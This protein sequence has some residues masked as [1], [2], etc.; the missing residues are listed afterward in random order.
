MA[1]KFDQAPSFQLNSAPGLRGRG[2]LL[3]GVPGRGQRRLPPPRVPRQRDAGRV[4]LQPGG[5]ARPQDG[6]L[7]A[8]AVLPRPQ[9]QPRRG[10]EGPRR[11]VRHGG[12]GQ[13]LR[14]GSLFSRLLSKGPF[15]ND[16]S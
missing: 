11:D 3:C 12:L 9:G 7:A 6:D 13:H 5:A 1:S 16:V 2:V 4:R 15:T 10:L 14:A 8:A